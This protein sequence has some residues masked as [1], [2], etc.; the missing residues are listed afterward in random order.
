MADHLK[1]NLNRNIK[2]YYLYSATWVMMIGPILTVFFLEKGLSFSQ[3]MVLQTIAAIATVITEVPSGAI[4][5]LYGRKVSLMLSS[6]SFVIGLLLFVWSPNY[7]VLIAG[8]IFAGIAISFKSGADSSLIY[9]TLLKQDRIKDYMR[10]QSRGHSYF[11]G[12]QII[13][14]ILAGIFFTA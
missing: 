3:I 12:A 13:G 4:A 9:D 1:I 6:L 2:Y 10:I 11:L 5:D 8:Q 7:L 14:S